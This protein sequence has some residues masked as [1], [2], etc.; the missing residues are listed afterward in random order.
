MLMYMYVHVA[1]RHTCV[2]TCFFII[3][4]AP[5]GQLY[6][7]SKPRPLQ[8]NRHGHKPHQSNNSSRHST[9]RGRPWNQR[10]LMRKRRRRR[11]G[12]RRMKRSRCRSGRTLL[13][14]LRRTP[15]RLPLL[16]LPDQATASQAPLPIRTLEEGLATHTR[17]DPTKMRWRRITACPVTRPHSNVFLC[18]LCM[19]IMYTLT[20]YSFLYTCT[21]ACL[22]WVVFYFVAV[23]LCC[24]R[25]FVACSPVTMPVR[26]LT[27]GAR[28]NCASS[29]PT[30]T[31]SP[32]C[33]SMHYSHICT[34]AYMYVHRKRATAKV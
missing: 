24:R 31:V 12:R 32:P 8:C 27:A 30:L 33:G 15:T 17:G 23:P 3:L 26:S 21:F 19:C 11:T 6:P 10:T 29:T 14:W 4:R 20:Q 13:E 25:I 7:A 18:W 1:L 28:E 22:C 5:L 16:L 2:F 34:C 9:E